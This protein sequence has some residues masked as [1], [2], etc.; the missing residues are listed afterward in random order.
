MT[1]NDLGTWRRTVYSNEIKSSMDGKEVIVMGWVSSVRDHG[2][3]VFMLINDKDGE[4]QITA[5]KGVCSEEIRQEIVKLKEQSS[6]AK[7]GR[8]HV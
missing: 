4:I 8:A 7:I 3:L 1:N 2:N 5:K 6:V